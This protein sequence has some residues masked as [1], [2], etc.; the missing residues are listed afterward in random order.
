MAIEST[1]PPVPMNQTDE[2][3]GY[4]QDLTAQR[5]KI[6][7]QTS[8]AAETYAR[9][10]TAWIDSVSGKDPESFSIET[11]CNVTD[12]FLTLHSVGEALIGG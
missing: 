3:R 1:T 6:N 10:A 2:I 12:Q 5:D 7:P 11:M 4:V 8:R 9:G